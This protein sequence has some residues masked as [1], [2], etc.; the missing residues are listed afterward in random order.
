[1]DRPQLGLPV[2]GDA[3]LV[4]NRDSSVEEVMVADD[5][6]TNSES[7]SSQESPQ[8]FSVLKFQE[9]W[10]FLQNQDEALTTLR[11]RALSGGLRGCRLRSVCWKLLLGILTGGNPQQWVQQIKQIRNNYVDLFDKVKINPWLDMDTDLDNPLSQD[12]ESPWHQYFCDQELQNVIK[13]D[14]VRTFP[15]VEF[16]RD[17]KI[18]QAMVNILFCYARDH[19]S[20]CYRQGMHEILAPLLFVVHCDYQTYVNT[21]GV[22]KSSSDP[23]QTILDPTY[24][25]EDTYAVFAKVMFAIQ[26]SYQISNVEPSNTGYFPTNSTPTSPVSEVLNQLDW[27]KEHLLAPL[28]PEL[29][30]HL[31]QMDVTLALFGIRWLRLLFGR[32]FPLQDLLVLWDAVFAE[33]NMFQLVN[34]IVVAMLMAIRHQLLTS[35]HTSCLT[36]LMRYPSMEVSKIIDHALF[37]KNPMA[38]HQ[39]YQTVSY[40][41]PSASAGVQSNMNPIANKKRPHKLDKKEKSEASFLSNRFK[42]LSL[43]RSSQS[44]S[45]SVNNDNS[46]S[47]IE[48]F[49]LDDPAVVRGEL[50]HCRAVMS[51]V[52][53]KLAQYHTVLEQC[54]PHTNIAAQQA[55]TG[56]HELCSLLDPHRPSPSPSPSSFDVEP[57]YEVG[58]VQLTPS[59]TPTPT[60]LPPPRS[61][62]DMTIFKRPQGQPVE[63]SDNVVQSPVKK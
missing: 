19:P 14:V 5:S 51:L 12:A 23:M 46:S 18:Q 60:N 53:L 58:E 35:D 39:P 16:F 3:N 31:Q 2:G 33:G 25:E 22:N 1:M 20:M 11:Q 42:R 56:I 47:I 52:Q 43:R 40:F 59:T 54:V 44:D 7:T 55:L 15:G 13:M 57:A 4:L 63:T 36:I 8:R 50:K 62:I 21:V 32:E 37:L 61:E 10:L 34:Y 24:V 28:D 41:H 27:I 9:E 48:G 49:M 30:Q 6:E 38:Y 45:I 17:E 26:G 29:H